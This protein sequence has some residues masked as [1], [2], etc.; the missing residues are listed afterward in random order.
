MRIKICHTFGKIPFFKLSNDDFWWISGRSFRSS[1][2]KKKKKQ[3]NKKQGV[4]LEWLLMTMCSSKKRSIPLSH[5]G[6]FCFR[7]PPPLL[8]ISIPGGV[9]HTPN[10]WNLRNFPTWLGTARKE[11]FPKKC[12]CTKLFMRNCIEDNNFYFETPINSKIIDSP[13]IRP[14]WYSG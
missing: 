1:L 2:C 11:Y 10:P 13:S 5:G 3:A 12:C 8:G 6:H 4:L 7:P 14:S 9:C